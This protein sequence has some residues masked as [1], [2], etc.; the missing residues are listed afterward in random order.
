R[1]LGRPS[2]HQPANRA[3]APPRAPPCDG[4]AP[5]PEVGSP[6]G[7]SRPFGRVSPTR[8]QVA[9]AF[10]SRPPLAGRS[11]PVR[12]ACFRHAASVYPEPGSNSPSIVRGRAP[13]PPPPSLT[14]QRPIHGPASTPRSCCACALSPPLCASHPAPAPPPGGT[15]AAGR[16]TASRKRA[17]EPLVAG[18]GF[19]PT[20]FGL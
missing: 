8:G 10:L 12:L 17:G 7:L 14:R 1:R 13:E 6:C 3:R 16:P 9:H 18:V 20:T 4:F 5:D 19:E 11:P 15:T 2:P